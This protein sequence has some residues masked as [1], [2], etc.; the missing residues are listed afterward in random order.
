MAISAKF[1]ADFSQF[2]AAVDA[3]N[4]SLKDLEDGGGKAGTAVNRMVDDANGA[5]GAYA[6]LGSAVRGLATDLLAMV[7]ARAA[8][9]FV[10]SVID[11][12]SALKDLS[13]QTH[14][15]VEELQVLA[16]AM[17][18]F[19]V[20]AD[21]LGKGLFKLSRGIAGGDDSVT[22][23]LHLMG[24]S[25]K[26]VEGLQGE[27]LFLKIMSGLATLQGGLRD[28]AGAEL[29]GGKLGAAMAGAS[30]GIKDAIEKWRKLNQVASTESVEAMDEFS[31]SIARANK[32]L[33]SMAANII[34]PAAG[35][36][37]VLYDAVNKGVSKWDIFVA[38]TKDFAYST[39][40]G[41]GQNASNLAT[42]LDHLN[43]QTETNTVATHANAAGHTAVA[44]AVD[45]RTQAQKF[46]AAL[47]ADAAVTLDAAQIKDLEHLR[48]IG[49]LNAKNAEGIGVS[50]AQYAK[51]TAQ[52]ET[53]KKA[54]VDLAKAHA[55][56]DAISLTVYTGQVAA[57]KALEA[58]RAKSYGAEEQIAMLQ[59]LAVAEED[60]TRHVLTNLTSEKDRAKVRAD[61][62]KAQA[63]IAAQ[64]ATL[65]AKQ[66][67]ARNADVLSEFNAHVQLNKAQGLDAKGA[68]EVQT[69]AYD[70]LQKAVA[71]LHATEK[72]G[73]EVKKQIQVLE[74]TYTKALYDEAVA[75][76]TLRDAY[77]RANT[78]TAKA[79]A[80]KQL[81]AQ[82]GAVDVVAASLAA[83]GGVGQIGMQ[84]PIALSNPIYARPSAAQVVT[85]SAPAFNGTMQGTGGYSTGS[86]FGPMKS[87][88]SG[89][90]GDFGSGTPALLHGREA[91]IPLGDG[92]QLGV[93]STVINQTIYVN[94]TAEE[95]ARKIA[96]LVM[97][98]VLDGTKMGA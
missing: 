28:T 26:D 71:A 62:D 67:A 7:T 80:L 98:S 59:R 51:Y 25:L 54:V 17:S 69:T 24:M 32:N 61:A 8:F 86:T 22:H 43:Q 18:E 46:M 16:G 21:T 74:A 33:S 36:F 30:E 78:E 42:V 40:P 11:D 85:S 13:Q 9:N 65:Q 73:F 55:D 44:K 58:Q 91:I 93:G 79:L 29:F 56:M 87:Y 12:A 3:A 49:A 57:L 50:G 4:R 64:I 41:V 82:T 77:A 70:T 31:E 19:G 5:A 39:L 89:G 27:E 81:L 92:S 66:T 84:N 83:G 14:I 47:E 97:R 60:L 20:D 72:P 15:N 35:G 88:A 10:K 34:G 52:V 76:D 45:T 37:N 6:G 63:E 48:D 90:I 75:Q 1:E 94:G 38:M 96:K 53:A 68:I 2:K 23:G 95:A